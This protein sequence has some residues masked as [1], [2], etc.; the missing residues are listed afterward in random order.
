MAIVVGKCPMHLLTV[1]PTP[2]RSIEVICLWSVEIVGGVDFGLCCVSG[3]CCVKGSGVGGVC[4]GA[5]D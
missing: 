1:G 4:D 3:V 5:F 2:C